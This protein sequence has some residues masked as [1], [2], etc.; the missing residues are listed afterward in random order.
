[1]AAQGPNVFKPTNGTG[2]AWTWA[3]MQKYL[4]DNYIVIA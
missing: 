2:A 4:T 3:D 1:M